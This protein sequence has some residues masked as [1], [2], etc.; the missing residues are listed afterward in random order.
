MQ[1]NRVPFLTAPDKDFPLGA[2]GKGIRCIQG[3]LRRGAADPQPQLGKLQHAVQ[4]RR[5]KRL[6]RLPRLQSI[7]TPGD[8]YSPG[9]GGMGGGVI[10]KHQRLRLGDMGLLRL[11]DTVLP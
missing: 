7:V 10:R 11:P 5:R 3:L 9:K 2:Y 6:P 1:A 8:G 4:H